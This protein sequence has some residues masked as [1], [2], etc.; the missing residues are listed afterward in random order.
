MNQFIHCIPW[1]H[2]RLVYLWHKLNEHCMRSLHLP[3][4]LPSAS[5]SA[6]EGHAQHC[7]T[8]T[9]FHRTAPRKVW[10]RS[11]SFIQHGNDKTLLTAC[12]TPKLNVEKMTIM[13]GNSCYFTASQNWECIGCV[14]VVKSGTCNAHLGHTEWNASLW[15]GRNIKTSFGKNKLKNKNANFSLQKSAH[16]FP[17]LIQG[18]F[19]PYVFLFTLWTTGLPWRHEVNQTVLYWVSIFPLTGGNRFWREQMNIWSL[20]HLWTSPVCFPP[21]KAVAAGRASSCSFH[22]VKQSLPLPRQHWV[23]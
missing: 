6:P 7:L 1:L 12:T 9:S 19:A 20:Q 22:G 21:F 15:K 4:A 3:A 18:F 14:Q 8:L 23:L 2:V 17:L 11:W 13:H 10:Q 5:D 16:P